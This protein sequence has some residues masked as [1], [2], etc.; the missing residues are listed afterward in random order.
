M[1]NI[2]YNTKLFIKEAR[3]IHGHKYNYNKVN[4][5]SIDKKVNITCKIHGEFSQF[6]IN[7]LA[8]RG[9]SKCGQIKAG[10]TR[11]ENKAKIFVPRAKLVHKNTYDYS[12]TIYT[13]SANKIEITCKLHG[14]F[15]IYP[16]D[17]LRGRGCPI[18]GKIKRAK[19]RTT[20][21]KEF[22]KRAKKIHK[23]KYNYS[24]LN[25]V[26]LQHKISIKC[27][28]HNIIF[29]QKP[30]DHLQEK[31][32][33]LYVS[34]FYGDYFHGNPMKYAYDE[35]NKTTDSTFGTLYKNTISREKNIKR[36][37]F[38]IISIWEN[39]FDQL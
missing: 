15:M 29:Q 14:S 23:D 27:K 4:F 30:E 19:S 32:C 36:A 28:K 12:K 21:E 33:I 25:Y 13:K 1:S 20:I 18:C 9:C 11:R 34:E 39:D 10:K 31:D 24:N 6:A 38:N 35:Y 26:N 8:G 16:R 5:I 7:H 2:K 37:G 22:I 3:N 17:H